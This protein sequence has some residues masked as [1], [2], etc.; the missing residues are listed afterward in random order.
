MSRW[1]VI[2]LGTEGSGK[3]SL[4]QRLIRNKFTDQTQTT[5]TP[6]TSE[7]TAP[8]SSG[9]SVKLQIW[10]TAGQEQYQSITTTYFRD[11]FAAVVVYDVSNFDAVASVAS[12][13]SRYREII[14]DGFVLVAA[15]KIDV[16]DDTKL[17]QE[18]KADMEEEV[19]VPV[20]LCSAK[21]GNG[22]TELFARVAEGTA[23]AKPQAVSSGVEL[24]GPITL[25][26][27]E[28]VP[29][30]SRGWGCC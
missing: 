16:I 4:I 27:V 25:Q 7:Y 15:N 5:V 3:T 14:P 19:G 22:V 13:I 29:E 26:P 9:S 1:K 17:L 12:W 21:T 23:A 30:Q 8:L 24:Q 2:L 11:S 18:Q 10:D 28:P 6:G 20:M